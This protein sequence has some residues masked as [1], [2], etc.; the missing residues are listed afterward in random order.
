MIFFPEEKKT[1]RSTEVFAKTFEEKPYDDKFKR[2]MA[3]PR[4]LLRSSAV[5]LRYSEAPTSASV[6]FLPPALL[7]YLTRS[8]PAPLIRR[9]CGAFSG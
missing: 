4:R 2:K 9:K 1:A 8:G 3:S 5:N 6:S 7:V